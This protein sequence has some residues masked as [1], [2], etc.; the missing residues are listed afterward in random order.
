MKTAYDLLGVRSDADDETIKKAYRDAAKLYHP[1]RRPDD[2]DAPSRFGK[3]AGAY[4]VLH[5]PEQRA[6]YDQLLWIERQRVRSKWTDA[7]LIGAVSSIV[8]TVVL[9]AGSVWIKPGV[10][11]ETAGRLE[12]PVEP[13]P[14]ETAAAPVQSAA[15]GG[16]GPGDGRKHAPDNAIGPGEARSAMAA[17][18]AAVSDPA[19]VSAPPSNEA[20]IH[21]ERD[22]TAAIPGDRDHP[23]L[24]RSDAA[25]RPDAREV[26]ADT[27]LAGVRHEIDDPDHALAVYDAAI[28]VVPDNALLF[29]SRGLVWRRK[30]DL[31]RALSDL[32]RAIRFAFSDANLYND[33][34]LI[35]LEKGHYQRAIA[36][37]E[38]AS[39]IDPSLVEAS[40]NRDIALRRESE[41]AQAATRQEGR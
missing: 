18:P 2:P 39:Q 7:V 33:R 10:R 31:V 22:I 37:F 8:F 24:P 12:R 38:R 20:E 3:I 25:D 6:A 21:P 41:A 32:D 1:D 13:R 11:S 34:G 4:A 14:T 15:A 40:I 19:P 36:D 29:H 5:D 28:R 16:E 27:K 30:G 17:E 23:E 26:P 9:V 35:W